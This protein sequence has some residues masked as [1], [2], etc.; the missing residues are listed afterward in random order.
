M[1]ILGVPGSG[2]IADCWHSCVNADRE[3]TDLVG[4]Q[5]CA[6]SCAPLPLAEPVAWPWA[7]EEG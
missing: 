1:C 6:Q 4:T 5:A 2:G 3:R 7:A